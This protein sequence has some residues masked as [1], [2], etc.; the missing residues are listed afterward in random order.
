MEEE[1]ERQREARD[2]AADD[3]IAAK[4]NLQHY[5]AEDGRF[6]VEHW[7]W[8]DLSEGKELGAAIRNAAACSG[9]EM[10]TRHSSTWTPWPIT[11]PASA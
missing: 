4:Y 8:A 2:A 7:L 10:Q 9:F 11:T 5:D 3:E 1:E 6:E